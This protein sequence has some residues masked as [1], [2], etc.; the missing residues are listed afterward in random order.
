[1]TQ[2]RQTPQRDKKLGGAFARLPAF[3]DHVF[4]L[5]PVA[6]VQA[7]CRNVNIGLST[8][9]RSAGVTCSASYLQPI[10]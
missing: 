4:L 6:A 2:G 3:C 9:I 5:F 1:M 7:S 10:L 8:R